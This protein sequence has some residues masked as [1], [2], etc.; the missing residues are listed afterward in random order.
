P[1]SY[2]VTAGALPQG[3]TLSSGGLLSGTPTSAGTFNFTVS[4]TDSSTG[5]GPYSGSHAYSI[6]VTANPPIAGS[7][8]LTVA[9]NSSA[10]PVTLNLTG[11]T[12]TTVAVSTAAGHGTATASGTSITYT[13]T[14]GYV[15]SDSFAYTAG[16]ADGTSAPATVSVTVSAPTITLTPATLSSGAIATAYSQ[17]V[18]ATGGTA[19][20]SYAITSGA[21]PAG[22]SLNPTTGLLAGTPTSGGSFNL[23][24]T[25]TDSSTGTGAPFTA[26]RAYTLTIGA[27][28]V[29]I[30]PATLPAATVATA[31]SQTVTASGGTAPYTYA[32]T[33]GALP[34]GLT[35][36]PTGVLSGT[37]TADGTFNVTI[38]ATDSSAGGGPYTGSRAYSLAVGVQ[39][40]I[41]G[42]V[43]ASVAA[44]SS[45]NPVT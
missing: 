15:G 43:S 17:T 3:L 34:A 32:V 27:P 45:A 38:T 12:A 1:Y 16:N 31:Y 20:Y 29:A 39:A 36:S 11:G 14:P 24:V 9:A 8:T 41:A 23:T 5:A 40:P 26:S 10:N 44:N 4:A 30:T 6:A 22:L 7:A 25:A 19:P 42:N 33:S 37:P 21:L 13:P 35:L 18:T 28:T 2:A